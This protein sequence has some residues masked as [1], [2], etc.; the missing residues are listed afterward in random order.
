MFTEAS[1]KLQ[2]DDVMFVD[3][4]CI[5]GHYFSDS[6]T[7]L[8]MKELPDSVQERYAA[9]GA[10]INSGQEAANPGQLSSSVRGAMF[11]SLSKRGIKAS[12]PHGHGLGL[13]V[14]DYPIIVSNNGLRIQDDC[15]DISSDLPMEINMVINLEASIYSPG[16]YSVHREQSFLVT[17]SG[18]QPLVSQERE[19]PVQPIGIR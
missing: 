2:K 1:Y 16:A 9:V 10:C 14:R 19:C 4:G 7:T 15:V 8:A 11:K 18:S 13:E 12:F 5:Y 6:G 3:F 17:E